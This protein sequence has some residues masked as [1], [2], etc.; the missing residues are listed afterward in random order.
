MISR[1][2]FRMS[3]PVVVIGFVLLV[4]SILGMLGGLLFLLSTFKAANDPQNALSAQVEA[5][6]A[7]QSQGVPEAIISGVVTGA[8]VSDHEVR[9]LA[10]AQA[11]AVQQA[12][13]S[14]A[15]SQV[16]R[17]MGVVVA[18]GFSLAMIVG[19]LVG[20][21]LGWLLVM[22]KRILQCTH[23]RAVVAAS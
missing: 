10:P 17:G 3:A 21:L 18:G 2:S 9:R 16:G 19:S 6:S 14:I 20:G 4:P 12:R 22:R 13:S 7:M 23:C 11:L 15:A 8:S 5:R 1:K